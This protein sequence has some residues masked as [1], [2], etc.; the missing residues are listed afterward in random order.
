MKTL[1]E[2]IGIEIEFARLPRGVTRGLRR[3]GWRLVRDGSVDTRH[4]ALLG[5]IPCEGGGDRTTFGGELVSPILDT[6]KDGWD[7]QLL[8]IL[9]TLRRGGEGVDARTSIHVHV[10]ATGLP[11]FAIRFLYEIGA[12]LEAGIYR[13][14]CGE[15]GVHRGDI[16]HDHG[17]ARPI[18]QQGPPVM[19]CRDGTHRPAFS[20]HTIRNIQSYQELR[21]ASGRYDT[22]GGKYAEARYVWLNPLSLLQHGTVEFRL[23]NMTTYP[24]FVLAWVKLCMEIVTSSLSKH[25]ELPPPNPLGTNDIT[26]EEILEFLQIRDNPT[27]YRL[28]RL[29]E[30]GSF[31]RG[32]RGW[33]MGHLGHKVSWNGVREE[34]IPEPAGGEIYG[35]N[36]FDREDVTLREGKMFF[37]LPGTHREASPESTGREPST[38]IESETAPYENATTLYDE[39]GSQV[40]VGAR[41]T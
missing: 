10:N 26:L 20:L 28:E 4:R 33:Q 39:P 25:S 14:S 22:T 31:S 29:W 36:E 1:I 30:L 24:K 27:I 32:I 6:T 21:Q 3:G 17:Y 41:T 12:Y 15:A 40:E 16:L 34:L 38:S 13:L 2:S 7:S 8:T 9:D 19:E 18:T 35:F 23:F 37:A 5:L 11:L